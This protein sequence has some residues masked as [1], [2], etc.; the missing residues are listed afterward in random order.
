MAFEISGAIV[1]EGLLETVAA[2]AAFELMPLAFES[3]APEAFSALAPEFAGFGGETLASLFG[4][5][6]VPATLAQSFTPAAQS[7][8][9]GGVG[10]GEGITALTPGALETGAAT[11]PETA[12]F[13]PEELNAISQGQAD[14]LASGPSPYEPT[15]STNETQLVEKA[16]QDAINNSRGL[17]YKGQPQFTP[18]YARADVAGYTPGQYANAGNPNFPSTMGNLNPNITAPI[19]TV[20][21]SSSTGLGNMAGMTQPADSGFMSGFSNFVDKHPFMTGAGIYGLASATGVLNHGT[22]SFN[23]SQQQGQQAFNNPYKFSPNFKASHPDPS[24][25]YYNA[26]GPGYAGG[27]ITQATPQTNFAI[28]GSA[29]LIGTPAANTTMDST[30]GNNSMFPMSEMDRS[31]YATPTQLPSGI[32]NSAKPQTPQSMAGTTGGY[33]SK[34]DPYTGT[35]G[36]AG[37]GVAGYAFGGTTGF[38]QG[39]TETATTLTPLQK[40][41]ASYN[42]TGAMPTQDEYLGSMGLHSSHNPDYY[43][44]KANAKFVPVGNVTP[45]EQQPGLARAPVVNSGSGDGNGGGYAGGSMPDELK[46][47]SGGIAHYYR[48]D[49]ATSTGGKG[50][51]YGATSRF[52]DMYDPASRYQAPSGTPD[53]GIFHDTNP[54]TRDKTALQASQIRQNALAKRAN[55]K[56]GAN[57][58]QPSRQMGQLSFAMPN[59]KG[60]KDSDS[61]QVLSAASGG[62]MGAN[63]G[64]YAAGGNPRLL[65]GPGD[66]MSDNIPATIGG[67]QP[68]RLADGE[69]VVPADVVSHLGNGSTDAGAKRLHQM[70][71]QVRMDRTGKKKQAPAVKANKYIPK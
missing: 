67:R 17:T 28:G 48:G 39:V 33:E 56:T 12:G 60:D 24:Q 62:I 43:F 20:L 36:M 54:S 45:M 57:Y 25:Y 66:G 26:K 64:G 53:V 27:G 42:E 37:G 49:L 30:V 29:P 6:A 47:A 23:A 10:A 52:L 31:Y 55:V 9:A 11:L 58:M 8:L 46:Y 35:M 50:D 2:D 3:L 4:N 21:P 15:A 40:L 5:Q 71:D 7:A 32:S 61:D 69:F 65:K 63:L 41:I 70:M 14:A 1:A 51:V 38:G 59:A 18:D 13:S 68:A 34:V 22:Q 44:D 19:N 16:P